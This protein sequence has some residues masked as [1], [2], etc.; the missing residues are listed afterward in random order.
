M[1]ILLFVSCGRE[2]YGDEHTP[3]TPTDGVFSFEFNGHRYHQFSDL[4]G[5]STRARCH[6][7]LDTLVIYGGIHYRNQ[8]ECPYHKVLFIIPLD[9]IGDNLQ[10]SLNNEQVIIL[11]SSS[12]IEPRYVF[13][14]GAVVHFDSV[15]DSS[16]LIELNNS[17][18]SSD[19]YPFISGTFTVNVVEGKDVLEKGLFKMCVV[20]TTRA[21]AA[22]REVLGYDVSYLFGPS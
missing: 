20:S 17:R 7:S 5:H 2:D 3:R 19:E 10:V 4:S 14:D 8:P 11:Q 6:P 1:S 12:S 9:R 22:S 18:S 15:L 21:F 13:G 16:K